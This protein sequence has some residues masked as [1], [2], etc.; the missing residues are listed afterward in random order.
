MTQVKSSLFHLIRLLGSSVP[1]NFTPS[2]QA[3]ENVRKCLKVFVKMPYL[4]FCDAA[5]SQ[6]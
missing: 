6:R 5:F 2:A 1:S 3:P 4:K